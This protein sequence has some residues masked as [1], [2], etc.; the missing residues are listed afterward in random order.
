MSLRYNK[1]LGVIIFIGFYAFVAC[2]KEDAPRP[3]QSGTYIS[4][5]VGD[6]SSVRLF[7]KMGEVKDQNLINAYKTKYAAQ[8]APDY[9]SGTTP[10]SVFVM[11]ENNAKF[12]GWNFSVSKVEN[13]YQFQSKD[14]VSTFGQFNQAYYNM[15]K[16]K[17]YYISTLVPSSTGFNYLTTTL[18]YFYAAP[19]SNGLVFPMINIVQINTVQL[20]TGGYY[21]SYFNAF[22]WNNV[23]NDKFPLTILNADTL[24]VQTNNVYFKR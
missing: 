17:P 23:F 21:F 12:D 8:F 5:K 2:K 16:Y 11:D 18:R 14:T 10:D 20:P 6:F 13:F 7:T 15:V 1:F 9:G 24:L 3:L 4:D 22:K 19:T